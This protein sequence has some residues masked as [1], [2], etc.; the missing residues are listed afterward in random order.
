MKRP[1]VVGR[2]RAAGAAAL[3]HEKG[4]WEVGLLVA[5]VLWGSTIASGPSWRPGSL[6]PMACEFPEESA[7]RGGWTFEVRCPSQPASGKPL[8]GPVPLLF[9]LPLDLNTADVRALESLPGIGPSRAGAIAAARCVERL[10]DLA[11]LARIPGIGPRTVE[12]LEGW[13]VIQ[14]A[15]KCAG[16]P[17]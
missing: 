13:A 5:V 15:P 2:S 7:A 17:P 11:S 1:W 14:A 8:R 3:P 12:G 4:A 6:I 9:G 10:G 16:V